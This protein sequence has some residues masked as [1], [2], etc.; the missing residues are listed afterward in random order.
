M[1]ICESLLYCSEQGDF[2]IAV[3]A[4]K[5]WREVQIYLDAAPPGKTVHIPANRR[6]KSRLIQHRRM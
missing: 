1:D 2:D 3:H 6:A 4:F 5:F